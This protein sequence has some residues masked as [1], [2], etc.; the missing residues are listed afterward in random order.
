MRML[1]ALFLLAASG[2]AQATI[3]TQAPMLDVLTHR[4]PVGAGLPAKAVCQAPRC[5]MC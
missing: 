1:F 4:K 2:L 5:W 3:K